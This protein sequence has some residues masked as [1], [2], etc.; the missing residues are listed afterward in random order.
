MTNAK[1]NQMQTVKFFR[2]LA[3]LFFVLSLVS[4]SDDKEEL[5][6]I[7]FP[8]IENNQLKLLYPQEEPYST[9]IVGGDGH[10][11]ALCDD[12]QILGVKLITREEVEFLEL[13]PLSTGE[14]AVTLSDKSGNSVVLS[15]QVSHLE[16]KLRVMAHAVIVEG[17]NMTVAEQKELK[18]KVLSSIPV[19]MGGS[20]RFVYKDAA[21][22]KGDVYFEKGKYD[23]GIFELREDVVDE[24]KHTVYEI[25]TADDTYSLGFLPYSIRHVLKS[26]PAVKDFQFVEDL[27]SKYVVDYENLEKVYALQGIRHEN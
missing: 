3:I 23:E 19:R 11:S 15:V 27:T 4:C 17:D 18:D 20:Y 26:S 21:H 9:Q 25:Q 14:V 6:P 8:A 5:H 13:T 22:S 16:F 1:Y 10:Y 12:E 24:I 2:T 7:S